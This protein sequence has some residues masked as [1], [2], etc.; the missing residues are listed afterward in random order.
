MQVRL[1]EKEQAAGLPLSLVKRVASIPFCEEVHFVKI[2]KCT[3]TSIL[4]RTQFL[5]RAAGAH[6]LPRVVIAHTGYNV[7]EFVW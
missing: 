3:G 4:R 5:R 7:A 1:E 2:V 6:V